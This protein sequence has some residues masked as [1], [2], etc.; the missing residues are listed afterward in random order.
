[1]DELSRNNQL[2]TNEQRQREP[3]PTTIRTTSSSVPAMNPLP[4][5]I[6]IQRRIEVQLRGNKHIHNVQTA[7][8]DQ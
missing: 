2:H 7:Q 5:N 8:N 6:Q 4:R 1:M 3:Q